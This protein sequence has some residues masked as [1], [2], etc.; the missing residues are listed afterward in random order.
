LPRAAPQSALLVLTALPQRAA[1]E[2]L[3]RELLAA[4]LA[5]CIQIGAT[6]HSLYHWRGEIET[7][8]ETPIAI[9]TSA[10]LYS[11]LEAAIRARH[12]YELPEIIAVPITRGLPAYL[13]WIK[14]ETAAA[15]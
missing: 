9:K 6:V 4:R 15:P 13:D 3:A 12:P 8:D 10:V 7:A 14:A 11:R 2:S 5:A 1:A